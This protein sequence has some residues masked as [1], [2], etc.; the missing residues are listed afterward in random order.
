MGAV[1]TTAAGGPETIPS[2]E[3]PATRTSG[4]ITVRAN[5]DRDF[6]GDLR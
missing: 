1:D 5:V 6:M 2:G 4:I 3:Q